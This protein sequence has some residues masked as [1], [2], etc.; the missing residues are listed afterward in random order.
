MNAF[1]SNVFNKLIPLNNGFNIYKILSLI[2]EV[3]ETANQNGQYPLAIW[4]RISNKYFDI[5]KLLT[6]EQ[7]TNLI[8]KMHEHLYINQRI[9]EKDGNK[10]FGIQ[11]YS[12]DIYYSLFLSESA[13]INSKISFY[14]KIQLFL[15]LIKLFLYYN[16]DEDKKNFLFVELCDPGCASPPS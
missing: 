4:N 8:F 2:L 12:S 7:L 11:F 10:I 6:T 14:I 3:Y 13:L 9:I 1:V 16:L 5:L 15:N